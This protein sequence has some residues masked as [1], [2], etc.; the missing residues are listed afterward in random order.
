MRSGVK[1]ASRRYSFVSRD[2]AEASFEA[3]LANDRSDVCAKR[4]TDAKSDL[5]C[6][7]QIVIARQN[8]VIL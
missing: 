4:K 3:S 2:F 1:H 7:A 6:V 5:R 8:D